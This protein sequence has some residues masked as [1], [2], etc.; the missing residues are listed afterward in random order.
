M[1]RTPAHCLSVT[2]S[3][4][5]EVPDDSMIEWR[6][7]QEKGLLLYRDTLEVRCALENRAD[8]QE[9]L[10]SLH[11]KDGE[12]NIEVYLFRD[13]QKMSITSS[14][15]SIE[16]FGRDPRE[17][18]FKDRITLLYEML[19]KLF[20]IQQDQKFH[21][22]V[23]AEAAPIIELLAQEKSQDPN[24]FSSKDKLTSV[25]RYHG[26]KYEELLNEFRLNKEAYV[27]DGRC[28]HFSRIVQNEGITYDLDIFFL[29]N[30]KKG[31]KKTQARITTVGK[32]SIQITAQKIENAIEDLGQFESIYIQ[33]VNPETED[34]I[35]VYMDKRR[36]SY[37]LSSD[38]TLPWAKFVTNWQTDLVD[39]LAANCIV[40]NE[41][42]RIEIFNNHKLC[43]SGSGP[44]PQ[45]VQSGSDR[46]QQQPDYGLIPRTAKQH[47]RQVAAR[48]PGV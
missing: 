43:R 41:E 26:E 30:L 8:H 11:L 13:I 44:V 40:H 16:L 29:R 5:E 21:M 9:A 37:S 28:K 7:L 1:F 35:N 27:E 20:V 42:R 23:E 17:L 15:S 48:E 46:T 39:Y 2:Q 22:K 47:P 18:N 4:I 31:T 10:I 36:I 12:V 33:T 24:S 14:V 45:L 25:P 32:S 19:Q 6:S 3:T 38:S 34:T